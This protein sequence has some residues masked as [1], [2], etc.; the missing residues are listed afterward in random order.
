[1]RLEEILFNKRMMIKMYKIGLFCTSC[2]ENSK[3]FTY[4]HIYIIGNQ[5]NR[6]YVFPGKQLR[7]N[8][9]YRILLV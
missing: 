7:I 5:S 4:T 2:I 1:M 3:S 6:F 9:K 8:F